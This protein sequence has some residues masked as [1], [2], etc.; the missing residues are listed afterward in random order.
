MLADRSIQSS[1]TP[2]LS[3]TFPSTAMVTTAS[4][5]AI[6][7]LVRVKTNL[8]FE[9]SCLSS[10]PAPYYWGQV[11]FLGPVH[12]EEGIFA[13]IEL[14]PACPLPGKHDGECK[15]VRYFRTSRPMSGIFVLA[16]K[17]SKIIINEQQ[18]KRPL[19]PDAEIIPPAIANIDSALLGKLQGTLAKAQN[20]LHEHQMTVEELTKER[21]RLHASLT[22]LRS[23][24]RV[25]IKELQDEKERMETR[26]QAQIDQLRKQCQDLQ[27]LRSKWIENDEPGRELREALNQAIQQLAQVKNDKHEQEHQLNLIK[28]ELEKARV[29]L[30]SHL[31][32]G[33]CG[34]TRLS[35]HLLD[36]QTQLDQIQSKYKELVKAHRD[37]LAHFDKRL[38]ET[39]QAH[40]QSKNQEIIRLKEELN[41][42]DQELINRDQEVLSLKEELFKLKS[43]THKDSISEG[44]VDLEKASL[45]SQLSSLRAQMAEKEDELRTLQTHIFSLAQQTREGDSRLTSMRQALDSKDQ[46]IAKLESEIRLFKLYKLQDHKIESYDNMD[47][48]INLNE[49]IE[50]IEACRQR[51]NTL[52]QENRHLLTQVNRFGQL[53]KEAEELS[54]LVAQKNKLM[55]MGYSHAEEVLTLVTGDT[56]NIT[57]NDPRS[58]QP[59]WTSRAIDK[60]IQTLRRTFQ[61]LISRHH[62]V[63]KSSVKN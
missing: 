31:R 49:T 48:L 52:E 18:K 37:N 24:H 36:T 43:S 27:Q 10:V 20:D 62:P 44:T 34:D 4:G 60:I 50:T 47:E 54:D 40:D 46:E 12:F 26:L 33:A 3:E 58:Q 22:K 38:T 1:L 35:N 17:C 6:G 56:P 45:Y 16:S 5:V 57:I 9:E 59:G 11:K 15:G 32:G 51:I 41:K 39:V 29:E 21:T 25:Q 7:D 61:I 63:T 28:A 55:D 19:Q 42:L 30:D 23:T 53:A 2:L 8:S 13:G 14:D